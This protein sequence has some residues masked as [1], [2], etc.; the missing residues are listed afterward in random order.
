MNGLLVLVPQIS[1][2]RKL[3]RQFTKLS[4]SIK[5]IW[6]ASLIVFFAAA[7]QQTRFSLFLTPLLLRQIRYKSILLKLDFSRTFNLAVVVHKKPISYEQMKKLFDNGELGPAEN[8]NPYRGRGPSFT[9]V[10]FFGRGGKENQRQVA[11]QFCPCEKPSRS[12]VFW[13]EPTTAQFFTS[14]EKSPRRFWRWIRR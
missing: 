3:S 13:G 5:S 9:S 14:N 2:G 12:W 11:K 4:S 8:P 6:E 10:F 7:A 1:K